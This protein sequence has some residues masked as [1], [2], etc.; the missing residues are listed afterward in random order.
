MGLEYLVPNYLNPARKKRDPPSLPGVGER[1]L[2]IT[3]P[4]TNTKLRIPP[5]LIGKSF[6]RLT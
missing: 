5:V 6:S 3:H 4:A 2:T 1:N